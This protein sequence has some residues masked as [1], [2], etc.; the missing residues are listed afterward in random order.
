MKDSAGFPR[1]FSTL[2]GRFAVL[3]LLAFGGTAVADASL[4][5]N[6]PQYFPSSDNPA[7]G[8]WADYGA[9][10]GFPASSN[11]I[12]EVWQL[13][14]M[15]F[16]VSSYLEDETDGHFGNYYFRALRGI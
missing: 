9:T 6:I 7:P 4:P 2:A 8:W 12:A 11:A 3:V 15:V 10:D 14:Q 5:G 13:R 16:A 1:S